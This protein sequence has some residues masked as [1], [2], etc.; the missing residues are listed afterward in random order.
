[1]DNMGNVENMDSMDNNMDNMDSMGNMDSLGNVDVQIMR[2]KFFLF[3]QTRPL[4]STFNFFQF[5]ETFSVSLR[6]A[7]DRVFSYE[8]VV[9][10][11]I[12]LSQLL[13]FSHLTPGRSLYANL[14]Q[15]LP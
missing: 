11:F 9:A 6:I 2:P 14:R 12:E 13:L 4:Q 1:M 15:M 5:V 8:G 7:N 3:A 10:Y